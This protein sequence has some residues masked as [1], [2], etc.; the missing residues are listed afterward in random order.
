MTPD[1][2]F[3]SGVIL[4]PTCPVPLNE[5]NLRWTKHKCVFAIFTN[6]QI[7]EQSGKMFGIL[8]VMIAVQPVEPKASV[9]IK[10]KI[11]QR[12]ETPTI[13]LNG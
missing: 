4:T 11:I 7:A 10:R 5:R 13:W 1:T 8:L 6:A 2:I 12:I 3:V 9:P